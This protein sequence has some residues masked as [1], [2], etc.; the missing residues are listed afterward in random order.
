MPF[1]AT[2][3]TLNLCNLP[4]ISIFV[5]T[6]IMLFLIPDHGNTSGIRHTTQAPKKTPNS[7]KSCSSYL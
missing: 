4:D 2:N 3:Y 1:L 5:N 6:I 7:S